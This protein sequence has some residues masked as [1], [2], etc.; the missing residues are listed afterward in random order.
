V[1]E[2]STERATSG[3][4]NAVVDMTRVR[5]EVD[6]EVRARRAAG[7]YPAS[8]ERE[9]DALFDRFAPAPVTDNLDDALERVEDA[10]TLDPEIPVASNNPAFGV[11]KKVMARLLGWYHQFVVQQVMSLGVAITN[12]LRPLVEKV[13]HLETLVGDERMRDALDRLEPSLDDALW[14]D[15]VVDAVRG[16]RGRVALADAGDGGL[17]GEICGAGVDAYGV[18]PRVE[19]VEAARARG[20]D[21]RTNE[22]ARHL[23]AV[24]PGDLS[25]LLLRGCVE[26]CSRPALLELVDQATAALAAGGRLVVMSRT[27][28]AWSRRRSVVEADLVP[29]RPIHAETWAWLLAAHGYVDVEVTFVGEPEGL[30]PVPE[31]RPDAAI[32]NANLARVS[33]T[34][35]EPEGFVVE[36]TRSA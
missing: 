19:L 13:T 11:V 15:A 25:G 2:N 3:P 36:A 7:L 23:D 29:G 24:E 26:R 16:V 6:A 5:A 1:G 21:V 10:S 17:L 14:Q 20:L 4:T 8:F 30:M 22:I 32:L 34:L 28:A 9:L 31:D 27:P 12:V 33:E 35:F 18:E